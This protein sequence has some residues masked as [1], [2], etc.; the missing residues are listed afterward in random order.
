MTQHDSIKCP[1]CRYVVFTPDDHGTACI[2]GDFDH[3][4]TREAVEINDEIALGRE[5][6]DD[7][8]LGR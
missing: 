5:I 2:Y 1:H 3:V 4:D 7:R 8:E 6:G